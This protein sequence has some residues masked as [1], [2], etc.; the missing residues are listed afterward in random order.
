MVMVL[1]HEKKLW[2]TKGIKPKQPRGLFRRQERLRAGP[3]G[4]GPGADEQYILSPTP[5]F[6]D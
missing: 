4:A 3:Q 5:I 2:Y 1:G 6:P